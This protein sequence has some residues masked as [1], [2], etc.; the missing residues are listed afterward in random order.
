MP[1]RPRRARHQRCRTSRQRG[2]VRFPTAPG[3][4]RLAR[5]R[6]VLMDSSDTDTPQPYPGLRS[7]KKEESD[8]F[9]GR[10][11]HIDEMIAKVAERYFLCIT[12]PSG[13]GKSS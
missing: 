8:I 1:A 5:E 12:G 9:F 7:F 13:C 6:G 11:D 3:S 2:H 4:A 10:D